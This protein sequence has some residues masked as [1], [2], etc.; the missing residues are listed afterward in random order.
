[1]TSI[2]AE[3]ER[4]HDADGWHRCRS[5]E[6]VSLLALRRRVFVEPPDGMVEAEQLRFRKAAAR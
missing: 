5:M 2:P 3:R 4:T 6:R 1:M